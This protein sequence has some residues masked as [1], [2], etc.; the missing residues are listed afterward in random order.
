VRTPLY[1]HRLG[2]AYGP[3]SS[4]EA[5]ARTLE[6]P[7]EG[8]ETDCC[9]TA[10]GELVL[11]HDPLLEVGTDLTGWAHERP[12]AQIRAG[13][14]RGQDGTLSEQHPLVLDELLELAPAEATLQLD[15][16][17][18]ADPA[19]AQR[20]VRA[21][22]ERLR[23]HPARERTE[24]ISFWSGACKLAA[25]LGFRARLVMIGDYRIHALAAWGRGSGLHG[26][27]IEHFL[28]SPALVSAMRAT[29][30][31]VTT[32]TINHAA[33]LAKILP[34]GLDGITSDRP[35]ELREELAPEVPLAA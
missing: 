32:G 27:C 31:S 34:L 17:A 24:V 15:V 26:V 20:T 5:L 1:A 2:R 30:L 23:D 29:G 6:R 3:D 9:L 28:L 18:Y 16:K 11:L 22:H 19:L 13:R 33:A 7:I 35:H 10:D 12:A 25:E 21:I 4:A 14:L 8:L